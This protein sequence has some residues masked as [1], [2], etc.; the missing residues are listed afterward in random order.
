MSDFKTFTVYRTGDLSETHDENQAP[1]SPDVPS[2]WGVVFP[3]GTCTLRWAGVVA[4]TSV[5]ASFDDAMKVHG[6]FEARYGTRIEWDT[7][8]LSDWIAFDASSERMVT[9]A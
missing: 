6:H 8:T 4:A 9:C 7:M 5:W 1:V 2:F 3:D